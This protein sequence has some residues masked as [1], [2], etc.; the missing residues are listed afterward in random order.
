MPYKCK[1][2]VSFH[3]QASLR[4][5]TKGNRRGVGVGSAKRIAVW[6][7][8]SFDRV[9]DYV[10]MLIIIVLSSVVFLMSVIAMTTR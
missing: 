2:M 7:V 5:A 10:W 3:M 6:T 4:G 1:I 8:V 9:A